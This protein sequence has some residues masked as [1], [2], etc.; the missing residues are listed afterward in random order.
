M[1]GVFENK[2][3][4]FVCYCVGFFV[5]N[6]IFNLDFL[7]AMVLVHLPLPLLKCFAGEL[8]CP[9]FLYSSIKHK[10]N[11]INEVGAINR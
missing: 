9:C 11:V 3:N 1:F 8:E 10:G 2:F 4:G 7:F 5:S 6:F